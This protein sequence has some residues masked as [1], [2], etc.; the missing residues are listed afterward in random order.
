LDLIN[1][2]AAVTS[3]RLTPDIITF[4]ANYFLTP[5]NLVTHLTTKEWQT[6]HYQDTLFITVENL[7]E[8]SLKQRTPDF[9]NYHFTFDPHYDPQGLVKI[10]LF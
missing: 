3:F 9:L 4:G 6:Q 1:W 5:L 10:D 7:C 2:H 8:I